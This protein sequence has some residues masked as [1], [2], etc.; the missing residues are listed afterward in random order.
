MIRR[1]P[2]STLFPYTTLFRSVIADGGGRIRG[3]GPRAVLE[4]DEPQVGRPGDDGGRVNGR[5]GRAVEVH[6]VVV[7]AEAGHRRRVPPRQVPRIPAVVNQGR[8][9]V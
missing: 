9:E 1:P 2:R 5:P 7:E 4:R 8:L 6:A 3:D